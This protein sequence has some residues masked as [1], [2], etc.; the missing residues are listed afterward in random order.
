MKVKYLLLLTIGP[1]QSFIAEARKTQDLYAGSRLLSDLIDLAIDELPKGS[2]V[3]FPHKNIR[4]KPNRFIAIVETE[5][6][7][8]VGKR[9]ESKIRDKFKE[10]AQKLFIQE[11][12]GKQKPADFYK[13][14]ENFLE[15][16]WIILPYKDNYSAI[17]ENIEQTL[18]A[19]KNI[20]TFNQIEQRGRKCSLCGKRSVLV[21]KK[22]T[23]NKRPAYTLDD[24]LELKNFKLIRGE[25]LCA[26]GFVK[27]FYKNLSFPSTAAIASMDWV[28]K[29]EDKELISYKSLFNDFDEQLFYEENLTRKYLEK[30]GHFKGEEELKKA[31]KILKDLYQKY[32]TPKKYYAMIMLDGDDM[33]KWLSGESLENKIKLK[34]FHQGVSEKLGKYA[35]EVNKI[36]NKS[37]GQC[38]YAGGDDVM[39]FLNLESLFCVLKKLREKFPKFENLGFKTN[40]KSSASA[41]IVV[42]HYKTPLSEV[43]K[44]A[45]K[46]EKEAKEKGN[47][48]AF[49]IAVLK[50]SG[51]I[52]KTV[53]KWKIK[54]K[55]T[56]D[57]MQS[58][59]LELKDDE[60]GFSNKFI[61][62]LQEEFNR[63]KQIEKDIMLKTELKRLLK[64]AYKNKEE[65][66]K[67]EEKVKM[68]T[69][70]LFSLYCE[71]YLVDLKTY[72]VKLEKDNFFSFL[73]ITDFIATKGAV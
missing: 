5:K 49:G 16:Y 50:H 34:E 1:V 62:V 29:I 45:R 40:D 32:G 14:I 30:Y 33:G 53:Y 6:P 24:A 15:I 23:N 54:D 28:S 36:I 47:R 18:G 72:L 42:A 3:V 67:K 46:M 8:K 48:D 69:E 55:W 58:L 12:A 41:G 35:D 64:R 71:S 38:V 7:K 2:E 56:V 10:L 27:R 11:F 43:L 66:L 37:N 70:E 44:W 31:K 9:I 68:W 26:V 63:I 61:K 13:Q 60:N 59:I 51:E 39:A 22:T 4:S 19:I 57:I 21:Y 73:N 20:R 17:Y 65:K 25:G 52:N